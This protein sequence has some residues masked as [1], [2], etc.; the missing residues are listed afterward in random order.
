[1]KYTDWHAHTNLSLCARGDM[2]LEV[3]QAAL[4]DPHSLLERQALTNHG[5]QVYFPPEI[6][7]SWS[8][9]DDPSCFDEFM[10]RGDEKLLSFNREI[11]EFGEERFLFGV[12]AELMGDG[13]LTVS[14]RV[15]REAEVILGSLHEMPASY[16][17]GCTK[18]D[19]FGSFL[20]YTRDLSASG[21]DIIA[22]PLRWLAHNFTEV[23]PD[24][25]KETVA[26]SRE[27][28]VAIELNPRI[29]EPLLLLLI[30]ETIEAGVP[31]AF[32][33]DAHSPRSVGRFEQH[34]R[35]IEY[36]GYDVGEVNFYTGVRPF[37][38]EA[39]PDR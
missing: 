6:A 12:E 30:R 31:M 24:L 38:S 22:H 15:K 26:I 27:T 19:M 8:F 16:Q 35:L 17:K 33:T 9:L 21:I 2:T 23:P 10:D 1:M 5:F 3:Y 37:L 11:E 36:A 4:E 14:E 7:W 28:G 20:A 39:H 13:R 18:E 29:R 25:V 32:A 34:L